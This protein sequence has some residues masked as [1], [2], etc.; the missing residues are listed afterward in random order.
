M[1]GRFGG[2][3]VMMERAG[4]RIRYSGDG[5]SVAFDP[6]DVAGTV[7]GVAEGPVDLTWLH[8]MDR[9]LAG[10]TDAKA[11]NYVQAMLEDAG[12]EGGAA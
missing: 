5:F 2:H 9:V 1:R 11:V 8:I 4:G 10:V 7:T 12:V 3:V 6:A